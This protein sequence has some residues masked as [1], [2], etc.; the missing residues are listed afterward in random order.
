MEEEITFDDFK[1]HHYNYY[2]NVI[3]FT[4][5]Y[6]D[7]YLTFPVEV[8]RMWRR[9]TGFSWAVGLFYLNRYMALFGHIPVVVEYFWRTSSPNKP[10]VSAICNLLQSYHQY[11]AIVVQVIVAA[12]LA[13]RIYALYERS[14]R[15]LIFVLVVIFTALGVGCWSV[16]SQRRVIKPEIYVPVG[17]AITLNY[18]EAI[19]MTI[20]WGGMFVFDLIIFSMTLYKSLVLPRLRETSLLSILMRDGAVYFACI[21]ASNLANMLTFIYGTPFTRGV[22]TTFTNV[23]SSTMTSRLMLNLRHP[24]LVSNMKQSIHPRLTED[25]GFYIDSL[26]TRQEYIRTSSTVIAPNNGRLLY[27]YLGESGPERPSTV[28]TDH[29]SVPVPPN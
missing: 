5:L 12:L 22:G 2:V 1:T 14:R 10:R 26:Q 9:G 29:E 16:V 8:E 28:A 25:L 13:I 20:A 6:Y 7:Y 23:I 11:L 3:S 17:C 27:D 15:V 4:I 21:V 18:D 24:G 19:H